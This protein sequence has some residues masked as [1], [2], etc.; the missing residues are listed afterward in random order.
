MLD[1]GFGVITG[2]QKIKPAPD[3]VSELFLLMVMMEIKVGDR[4]L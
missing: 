3:S 1:R 4:F 2:L